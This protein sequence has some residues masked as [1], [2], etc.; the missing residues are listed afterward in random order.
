MM[1]SVSP[2]P[3]A[4]YLTITIGNINENVEVIITDIAGKIFYT[5]VASETQKIEVNTM[6]FAEGMYS[7]QIHA[8]NTVSMKK[9]I[10]AK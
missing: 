3:V 9:L 5:T 1:V 2:N 7:V 6:D 4:N 10:V 8:G